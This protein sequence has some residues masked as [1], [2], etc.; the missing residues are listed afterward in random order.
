MNKENFWN[1]YLIKS[2]IIVSVSVYFLP[3]LGALDK[4]GPQ[5]FTLNLINIVV[6]L[7]SIN[8]LN[9]SISSYRNIITNN[10]VLFYALFLIFSLF[11][12]LKSE[13]IAESLITFSNYFSTFFCFLNLLVLAKF[14][15][16]PK[17]F[18]VNLFF[19]LF[20]VEI[21]LVFYPMLQDLKNVKTVS[22]RSQRYIGAAANINIT[23]FAIV[24]KLPIAFYF[25]EIRKKIVSKISVS[26][27][28]FIS[29]LI[30]FILNTRGAFISI[31]IIIF[32][33]FFII[34]LNIIRERN[35][36]KEL[37]KLC[38]VVTPLIFSILASNFLLSS[39]KE[40][41][42]YNRASTISFSTQDGSVNQRIRF[43][44]QALESISNSPFLGIGIGNW[45]LKSIEYDKL[46]II[47]YIVPYHAHNDYLQI[48]AESGVFAL[49]F[50]LL[51]F[52]SIIFIIYELYKK[53]KSN[54]IYLILFTSLLIYLLDSLLN[55]PVSRPINQLSLMLLF[56]LIINMKYSNT[57]IKSDTSKYKNLS[58]LFLF[59]FS[60]IS[61]YSSYKNFISLQ[62]QLLLTR[63]YDGS[64]NILSTKNMHLVQ[65][66]F[67]NLTATVLPITDVKA[68]YYIKEK[69]YPEA[70]DKIMSTKSYNPYIGYR[71][72]LLF[73]AY[74]GLKMNDSAYKY[75]KI[76]FHKLP[77]NELHSTQYFNLL[78]QRRDSTELI[79]AFKLATIKTPLLW[80]SYLNSIS[81]II[82]PGDKKLVSI[83]DS[84]IK[85]YP[86]DIGFSEMSKFIKIGKKNFASSILLGNKA[87][88][89]FK[90]NEFEKAINLYEQAIDKDPDEYAYYENLGFSYH[91]LGDFKNAKKYLKRV[92]KSQKSK[93][94]KSEFYMGVILL[95]EDRDKEACK[96]LIRSRNYNYAGAKQV[97]AL[98]CN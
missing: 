91:K 89:Y 60:F 30:L 73:Q 64:T 61:A 95:Q 38:F 46:D 50:Y 23:S 57:Q 82:G 92:I 7:L 51:I 76:A 52:L 85:V 20:L 53:D 72:S 87:D 10:T 84:L 96:Y 4:I 12:F 18:F 32:M 88:E 25:M 56:V 14:V 36:K 3:N 8:F 90:I 79:E 54:S 47:G 31:I 78:R 49:L 13:N 48:A 15:K 22:A 26:F 80:K 86:N 58:I 17:V 83:I 44:K 75:I 34:L 77:N 71:E 97:I 35:Y 62:D 93:T 19:V 69:K 70:I 27:L 39:Q 16:Q 1:Q 33:Y 9:K 11:S 43:Y 66:K 6:F 65:E 55:F 45:K 24:F 59:L 68:R 2:L 42:I 67:P 98:Y 28:I 37:I 81:E 21:I 29:F 74:T 63:D 5:W 40:N 41:T 94:G